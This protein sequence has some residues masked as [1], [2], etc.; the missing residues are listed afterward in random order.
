M[1]D[2]SQLTQDVE[3]TLVMVLQLLG[4]YDRHRQDFGCAA[5]CS[6]IVLIPKGFQH[7]VYHYIDRYTIAVV[8][9]ASSFHGS[10]AIPIVTSSA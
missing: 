1:T 5:L 3:R 4:G 10:V 9:A 8:H 7:I 6:A 2:V